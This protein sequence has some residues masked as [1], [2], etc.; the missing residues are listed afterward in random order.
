M[1]ISDLKGVGFPFKMTRSKL[2]K[3][4]EQKYPDFNWEKVYLLRGKY[5]QQHRL[6]KAVRTLFPVSIS[7]R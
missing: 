1:R 5:A 6:E 7:P 3:M 4:L 2:V